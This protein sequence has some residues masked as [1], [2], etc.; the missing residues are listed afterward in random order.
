MNDDADL[1]PRVAAEYLALADAL[2]PATDDDWDTPSLCEGW[3]IREVI[4]HLTMPSRYD[5]DAFMAELA[6]REFDFGRL[7]NDIAARDAE[8]PTAQ[9]LADLRADVLL[10]WAPPEGGYHGALNHVVI[11]GLDVS[12]PLGLP[13]RPDDEAIRTV[14][15]GLTAGGVHAHFGT[16]VEGRRLEASDLDWSFGSGEAFRAP[17]ADIALALAGRRLPAGHTD[18]RPL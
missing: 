4:A 12:V 11:H 14:L 15:D 13:H 5:Q 8:L 1:Q 17:A 10:Q 2:T 18:S 7:S 6:Q 3:R 9:L 16:T